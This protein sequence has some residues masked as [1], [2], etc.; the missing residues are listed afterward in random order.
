MGKPLRVLIVEDSEEGSL[1]VIHHLQRGGYDPSWERVE[2]PA[3][4]EA[5]LD[6]QAWDI[7]IAD[8][9]M[10]RFGAAPA[11]AV[12][13]KKELDLPFII[14]SGAVGEETV[15][16]AMRAGAHDYIK[17]ENL[18]RLL[19]VVERELREARARAEHR[20]V[21]EA[22]LESL[23]T[24]METVQAIP[25][26]LLIYQHRPPGRLALIFGNS[27]AER[28]TGIDIEE[29]LGKDFDEI[30]PAARELGITESFLNVARTD[31]TF[32]SD[33]L[34][35]KDERLDRIFRVRVFP[36][37]GNRLGVAFDDVTEHRRAEQ[38]LSWESEANGAMAKLSKTLLQPASIEEI[39]FLLLDYAKRLT[40][41]AFGYVAYID[42]Q[43]GYLVSPTLTKDIWEVCRV[44]D[45]DIVFEKFGGLWGWVLNSRKPLLTNT[46]AN[47]PR[48]TGTPE[49]HIPIRR[50]LSVPAIIGDT[51]VGQVALANSERDYCDRDLKLAERLAA[52]Y[53]IAI[54]C[55]RAEKEI[56]TR[57][58]E[59]TERVKEL[60][61][62]YG[63][64]S[65]VEKPG[66]SLEEILQGTVDLIPRSWQYPEATC[67]RITV[68]NQE[69]ATPK[70][71]ET[72]WK[73]AA[74]I[75]A[76]GNRIGSLEVFYM[77]EK[78]KSD[79]G[80]FLKEERDLLNAVAQMLG[81]V[82]ER[83]RTEEMLEVSNRFLKIA[84]RH[85]EMS[86][87][88]KEFVDEI[89]SFTGCE[90]AGIR[91]LDNEGNIPYEIYT[92]F[93][94]EFYGTESPLSIMSDPC[95]CTNVIKGDIN[96]ELSFYTEGGSFYLN[97]TTQFLA[98]ISEKDKKNT[99]NICN[100][101]GYESVVLLPI[102]AENRILGLIH[103]ADSRE[104]MFPLEL[105]K[106]LE[107]A[108]LQL[109]TAIVRVQVEEAVRGSEASYRAL[110]ASLEEAVKQK[111]AQLQQ[112]ES[113]AAIGRMV[114]IVAHEVRNPLQNI[115][116]GVDSI[117]KVIKKDRDRAQILEEI[118]YGVDS[119]NGLISD[120]LNYSRPVTLEYSRWSVNDIVQQALKTTA[121][122]LY[123]IRTHLD[124]EQEEKNIS[125]DVF[126][127]NGV[128][129][130][131]ISN[132]IQSMPDGG[133]LRI[134]S[135]F[136]EDDGVS[137]LKLAISD[138]G[139]G[140]GEE[141]LRQIHEPFFT[142]KSR[143]TG[144]GIPIC[145]KV[146]EA[147]DGKLSITSKV[148]EG[149]TAEIRLPVRDP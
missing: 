130:N 103:L 142:T 147:H 55:K 21:E 80:P 112:A 76:Y 138:S 139:C 141:D 26:G 79:E 126:K 40:G 29:W 16:T 38:A 134:R 73:Q 110:S 74:D 77:E 14:V 125:V 66:I 24:S 68:E 116:M 36:M 15:V 78:P 39:S 146:I 48:S 4:M 72:P 106:T 33:E 10:P 67:A 42:P 108:A 132:A 117:R 104:N 97:D 59:L 143:G 83:K 20:R 149:T 135:R 5:A 30:W 89:Q 49:G 6:R 56:R 37:A 12:I 41:S 70:C 148:G 7:V 44:P 93:S 63:I 31:E 51:L 145:K 17:R 53:A 100:Q 47:D 140:I 1:L 28:L 69:F 35:Y 91:S 13:R 61:C 22:L 87:L 32:E 86:A 131:L 84:N 121:H 58:D 118:D 3:E 128:L 18:A 113:L 127:F 111:V 107:G 75:F 25:S 129:V 52:L 124:L 62:L 43:T 81:K 144:L 119:L 50:F 109:G 60:N 90:A 57:S 133:D 92:G 101:F 8:H 65:L 19:P 105:V 71:V 45:K 85:G 64:S 34:L 2:T 88:L 120:L 136:E 82:I 122:K 27:A 94:K 9:S 95:M 54:Q 11:L 99:R 96:P 115:Q 98:T 123:G 114:S 137:V 46:P 23:Q 102:R